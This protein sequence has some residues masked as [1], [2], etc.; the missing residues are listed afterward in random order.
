MMV[1]PSRCGLGVGQAIRPGCDVPLV[2]EDSDHDGPRE[3]SVASQEACK[4]AVGRLGRVDVTAGVEAT[5]FIGERV[6][7]REDARLLTGRGR[8]VD[9]VV[10]A[11]H[12]ARR[13]RP[14]PAC[15]GGHHRD[16]HRRGRG[17]RRRACGAHV[18]RPRGGG[19]D[20]R[21]GAASP[22]RARQRVLRRRPGR[23]RRRRVARAG[24][25]R[26]RARARPL[27]RD[28]ALV[29][30]RAAIADTEHRV[31]PELDSNIVAIG[32]SADDPELDE[33]FATAAHVV[34]ETISQHRYLAVPMET[35]GIVASWDPVQ[36]AMTIWISTQGAHMARDHFAGVLGLD[37]PRGARD[38]R[39]R[40]RRVRAE[41][42]RR[43]RGDRA[44]ARGARRRPAR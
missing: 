13:V 44:R 29:R 26:V 8:Y 17:A 9:D 6:P 12:D 2:R 39:R 16:R 21:H 32:A 19:D 40:R 24:R 28:P 5:R 36:Q 41:D 35:R 20:R 43:A 31:H 4:T 23:D 37:P 30:A 27:R 14:Q 3:A 7:R 33:V 11:G 18:R 10:A 22:A 25:G 15:R 1:P 34:T 42:Q 38:R